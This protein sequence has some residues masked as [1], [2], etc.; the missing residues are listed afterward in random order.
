MIYRYRLTE[1]DMAALKGWFLNYMASFHSGVEHDQQS[2][3]LKKRHSFR[4]VR[5]IRTIGESLG[6]N[7]NDLRVAEAMAIMHDVGRFEQ[8]ARYRTFVDAKSVNHADLGV[9][10]LRESGILDS[11]EQPTRDLILKAIAYHNRLS[12]PAEEKGEGLFFSRLL[13]DADKIDIF[14]IATRY[15]LDRD[16]K[17]NVAIE[18]DL[19]D[20]DEISGEIIQCL[21]EG[22]LVRSGLLK[23]LNDFK[24]LQMGWV[25]DMNFLPALQLIREKG[26]IE[27]I[28]LALP[29]SV[30]I[31]RA[32]ARVTAYLHERLDY[33][34]KP[35]NRGSRGSAKEAGFLR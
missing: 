33:R 5:A 31:D 25:Y 18:L 34:R 10:V 24:L 23:S 2:Y 28:R 14:H 4:V 30:D 29:A 8:Y 20:S 12:I 35:D 13:R 1:D 21:E 22:R 16:S 27:A 19:P 9:Q 32:Y 3:V 7:P 26:Y 6:L 15:Y 17:R 11:L